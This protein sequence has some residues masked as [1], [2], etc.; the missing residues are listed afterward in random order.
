MRGVLRND[1]PSTRT[2]PL[3][4]RMWVLAAVCLL[5][6]VSAV[7]GILAAGTRVDWDMDAI[8]ADTGRG[9]AR[10]LGFVIPATSAFVVV[11]LAGAAAFAR[12]AVLLKPGR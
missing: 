5:V 12:Q 9:G 3:P 1:R 8:V 6:A 2:S 10:S 7:V 4:R 11:C